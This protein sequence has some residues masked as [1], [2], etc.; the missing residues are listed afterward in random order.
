MFVCILGLSSYASQLATL[1]DTDMDPDERK[2]HLNTLKMTSYLVC[3]FI[4]VFEAS[5]K[6]DTVVAGKVIWIMGGGGGGDSHKE[7][8]LLNA[9]SHKHL[10]FMYLVRRPKFIASHMSCKIEGG[11]SRQAFHKP[12]NV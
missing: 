8:G 7:I 9:E 4:D 12:F 2:I 1:L 6:P 3:Q 10:Y 5:T 11:Q